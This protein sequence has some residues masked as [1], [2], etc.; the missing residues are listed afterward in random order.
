MP[1]TVAT[2]SHYPMYYLQCLYQQKKSAFYKQGNWGSSKFGKD[3][4]LEREPDLGD[5]VNQ[6][7]SESMISSHILSLRLLQK[8]AG[9]FWPETKRC[10]LFLGW[11]SYHCKCY[12]WRTQLRGGFSRT[13]QAKS[14]CSSS[15][16]TGHPREDGACDVF[17]VLHSVFRALTADPCGFFAWKRTKHKASSF[18]H[19]LIFIL[20]TSLCEVRGNIH[21]ANLY[22]LPLH[23]NK[24][25]SLC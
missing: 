4:L 10:P 19:F 2:V 16:S 25:K 3:S 6:E 18:S 9:I 24:L 5:H 1:E 8:T 15:Q 14:K 23:E 21:K 11:L 17:K 7:R 22:H 12:C 20:S 13:S